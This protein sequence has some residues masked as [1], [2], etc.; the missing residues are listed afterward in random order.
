MDSGTVRRIF[1][2][3]Y[4]PCLVNSHSLLTSRKRDLIKMIGV[5]IMIHGV[6]MSVDKLY[7][8]A[9]VGILTVWQ[10]HVPVNYP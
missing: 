1:D 6:R 9:N 5:S 3:E 4:T 10:R 8:I 2:K 7:T